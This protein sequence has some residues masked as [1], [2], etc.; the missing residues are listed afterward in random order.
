MGMWKSQNQLYEPYYNSSVKKN[1]LLVLVLSS[2]LVIK[3]L[4]CD[5]SPSHVH[6]FYKKRFFA[7]FVIRLLFTPIARKS[8]INAQDFLQLHS[9]YIF[10]EQETISS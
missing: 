8:N 2:L 3:P 9:L 5:T 7:V 10:L 1:A 4:R 6:I